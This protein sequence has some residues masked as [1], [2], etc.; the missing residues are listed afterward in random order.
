M[1]KN[2]EEIRRFPAVN[3]D[4]KIGKVLKFDEKELDKYFEFKLI[5]LRIIAQSQEKKGA[6]EKR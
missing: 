3:E 1:Y 2:F 4:G 5:S 6:K